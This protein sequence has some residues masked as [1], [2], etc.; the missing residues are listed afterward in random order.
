MQFLNRALAALAGQQADPD[1]LGSGSGSQ[2]ALA[3]QKC[4]GCSASGSHAA[5]A[6]FAQGMCGIG[7]ARAADLVLANGSRRSRC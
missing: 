4:D 5:A 1:V 3:P 7:D 2:T 6:V